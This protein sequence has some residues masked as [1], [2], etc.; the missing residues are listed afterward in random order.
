[1]PISQNMK[2]FMI[3]EW[4]RKIAKEVGYLNQEA[5]QLSDAPRTTLDERQLVML[6][7]SRH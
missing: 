1:M 4:M 5:D 2:N 7:L 3:L 6:H